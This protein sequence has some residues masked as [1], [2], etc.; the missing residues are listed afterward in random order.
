MIV[1]T[2]LR[3]HAIPNLLEWKKQGYLLGALTNG[4]TRCKGVVDVELEIHTRAYPGVWSSWNLLAHAVL[5]VGAR[6]VVLAGDD[7]IPD[8]NLKADEIADQFLGKFPTGMGV[9]QPCGDP[10]GRD[11][12]GKSAA[13]RICGSP[14][15]GREWILR[16]YGGLGPCNATYKAFYADED[17]KCYAEKKGCL[18]MRPDLS[19]YHKHWSWGHTQRQDY[20]ERNQKAW[21]ADKAL[22]EASQKHGFQEGEAF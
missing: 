2:M 8:P 3:E 18:W 7:M 12:S 9:M 14:W 22:F 10:Q 20:H 19:Q 11:G 6:A 15:V 17:L 1:P 5:R 13:E 16:A 4:E 21:A